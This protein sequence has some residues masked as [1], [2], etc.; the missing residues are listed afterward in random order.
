MRSKWICA[1]GTAVLAGMCLGSAMADPA[2]V[3]VYQD[4]VF[5]FTPRCADGMTEAQCQ[6][7]IGSGGI[8]HWLG[9]GTTCAADVYPD[10]P[11]TYDMFPLSVANAGQINISGASLFV[12][13]FGYPGT[14][15]DCNNS[16]HDVLPCPPSAPFDGFISGE[17]GVYGADQLAPQYL[18]NNWNGHWL[19]QYRSVGSGNGLAEFVDYQLLGNL[20]NAVPG[21]KGI[22]NRTKWA[23]TGAKSPTGCPQANCFPAPNCADLNCDNLVNA[24]DI[25]GFIQALMTGT[26]DG[27]D[28]MRADYSE[29]GFIT[30]AD[31][32]GFVN[33]V[34][35]GICPGRSINPGQTDNESG[36]PVC[37]HSVD[38]AN[39]DVATKWFV[40]TGST[41]TAAWNQKPT[42]PGYGYNPTPSVTV[43][44]GT[45]SRTNQLKTLARGGLSMNTNTENPDANTIF[46]T[47]VA[48]SPAGFIAN[49]GAGIGGD[50]GDITYTQLQYL[51][52]TGRMPN[53]ENLT[54]CTRDSGSGTRN[55]AMN[56]IGVDPSYA[57]GDNLGL[58]VNTDPEV[59]L[60]PNTQPTNCGGSGVM[61]TAV[62]NRRL[63][64]GYTGILTTSRIEGDVPANKYEL[65]N[66]KKDI[67]GA[68]SFVRPDR[69]SKLV[70]NA[71]PNTGY[72]IGGSQTLATRGDPEAETTGKPSMAN[73][74]ARDMILNITRSLLTWES[75]PADP[76]NYAC[77]AGVL[78]QYYMPDA[79]VDTL[80][81]LADPTTFVPNTKLNPLAQTSVVARNSYQ[82]GVG[83]YGAFSGT[84][85]GKVPRRAARAA[86]T[87]QDGSTNGNYQNSTGAYTISSSGN[88]VPCMR[89][90]GDWNGDSVRNADDICIMMAAYWMKLNAGTAAFSAHMVAND[91]ATAYPQVVQ[92]CPALATHPANGQDNNYIIPELFGDYD[93][94]GDFTMDDIRYFADGLA[95]DPASGTLNRQLGFTTVDTVWLCLTGNDNFFGTVITLNQGIY[96]TGDSRFDV[97][98]SEL[99]AAKGAMPRGADGT[100]DATD[101]AYVT[102]NVFASGQPWGATVNHNGNILND[103]L[104]DHL[105]KDLSCDMTAD[106]IVSQ[107]DVDLVANAGHF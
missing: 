74:A 107:A 15:N 91:W 65:L 8:G 51:W 80:P 105:T 70:H 102:G 92:C 32:T 22:I 68:G 62:Q 95:I 89:I 38:V 33:A 90:H 11:Y 61:E 85:G 96:H 67:A 45:G 98:G 1:I 69:I 17:C 20:P 78:V 87:Y 49:R 3:C 99:G 50:F 53:G 84:N 14:T 93:G 104:G 59:Q 106:L 7:L 27:C 6:G 54:A 77:P 97:A 64:V 10:N 31:M 72:Q 26:V 58:Q 55:L 21:E 86:G 13:F 19:L 30:M 40:Q 48:F 4:F 75:N 16:D 23:D 43:G 63:A 41:A 12:E 35:N 73:P 60:G 28:P 25:Q 81:V 2:G 18:C 5:P 42:I 103:Y 76:S 47:T 9:E 36:T 57:V 24:L 79:S 39:M 34:V 44:A 29:D 83:A 66:V 71:D 46:D 37:P 56:C 52:T 88:V 94:D 100:V 82:G 101:A